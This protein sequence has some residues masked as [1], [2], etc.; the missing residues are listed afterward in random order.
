MFMLQI[1]ILIVLLVAI[2]PGDLYEAVNKEPAIN[3][4]FFDKLMAVIIK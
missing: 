4:L 3:S 2:I 1:V